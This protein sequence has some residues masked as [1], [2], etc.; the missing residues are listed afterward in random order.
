MT[1]NKMLA[2]ISN[3]KK[4]FLHMESGIIC[5]ISVGLI[6]AFLESVYLLFSIGGFL[7]NSKFFLR[8]VLI[9]CSIGG[10]L[11]LCISVL[12]YILFFRN[13]GWPE[14]KI[15]ALY[16]SLFLSVGILIEIFIY[17]MDIYPYGGINKWSLKTLTLIVAAA[18]VSL[19]LFIIIK[20]LLKK[21]FALSSLRI[22]N[23]QIGINLAVIPLV[24][25]FFGFLTFL[26]S[27]QINSILE[28]KAI[29]SKKSLLSQ[30]RGNVILILVD[31]LRPDHLSCN[32]YHLSTSPHIDSL[33]AQGVLFKSVLATSTW[34]V[35]THMSFFTG[36]YPSSHGAYS[37]F[38][39]LDKNVPTMAEILSRN[40]YRTLS[41]Y[42]NPLLGSEYGLDRGFDAAIGVEYH[43]K[44][45][46][47][48]TRLHQKFIKKSSASEDI[49]HITKKWIDRSVKHDIPYFV[50]M[51]LNDVHAPYLPVEPYFS[52]FMRSDKIDQVNL[53][54]I[55]KLNYD[56]KSG[57]E[58]LEILSRLAEADFDYLAR[59]Y[60]SNV[61]Y[62]DELIGN[63]IGKLN[64]TNKLENTLIIITADHGEFLG[65]HHYSGHFINDLSNPGLRIPL[66]LWYPERLESR[67]VEN[68]KSQVDIFPTVLSL[69][70]IENQI[71]S[72]I[73]G[74]NLFLE[75]ESRDVLAEF[76]NDTTNKFTRAIVSQ[77]TKLIVDEK[78]GL[79]MY[80]LKV[81]PKEQNNLSHL[82]PLR[83]EG[84][85]NKLISRVRS[86][87]QYKSKVD[88]RKRRN[89]IRLL[90]SLSYIN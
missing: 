13:K 15:F 70:G 90:K 8:A 1:P 48:L 75:N 47:T 50:F 24:I 63:L 69:L 73:Q 4:Y 83:A 49:I 55:N 11:G 56:L 40:G 28:K 3:K 22:F 38:S 25:L 5:G 66:I 59:M 76:W 29:N 31:A 26:G 27:Q 72:D 17:L 61:R 57:K 30:D 81:D 67:I 79:E 19:M 14:N 52:E 33:A 42:N 86:F 39:D 36:L 37:L 23:H 35:P 84:L 12:L 87:K 65:E 2:K 60:D 85:Y 21:I 46:L 9:Y 7:I 53:T 34:S 41:I 64:A 16:F 71:P 77:E 32:G 68:Y 80:D 82:Q 89:L 43:Q 58:K 88:E 45:S 20:S 6:L 78:G 10:L 44:T 74:I 18:I 54:L 62:V 51:N